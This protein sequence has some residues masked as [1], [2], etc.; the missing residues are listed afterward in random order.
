M[1]EV[2]RTGRGT[3]RPTFVMS[4]FRMLTLLQHSGNRTTEG[5]THDA[6]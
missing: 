6:S 5:W 2:G 3:V 1:T 4:G